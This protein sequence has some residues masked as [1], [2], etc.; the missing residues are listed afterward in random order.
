MRSTEPTPELR[1]R[2]EER[3]V[4]YVL[5]VAKSQRVATAAGVVRA[6]VLAPKL[7]L[8]AW[9]RLSA[10][11][12]AKGAALRHGRAGAGSHSTAG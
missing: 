6:D 1:A 10:G 3:Q 9:Q 8:R 12:R 11:V 2:I 7:A 5:A 4:S